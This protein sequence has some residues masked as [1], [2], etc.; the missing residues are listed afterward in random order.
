MSAEDISDLPMPDLFRLE[1]ETQ[2]Q[3]LIE[4]LLL[5]ERSPMAAEPLEASM[6]AAHSLKG[7]ARIVGLTAGVGVAHAMED[8]LV[9]A[10]RGQLTVGQAQIDLLL[11]GADLLTRIAKAPEAE[12]DR[13]NGENPAEVARFLEALSAALANGH[14]SG[15]DHDASDAAVLAA[16][17]PPAP[18][19]GREP[20][21]PEHTLES[22]DRVLRV[23]AEN[24]NRLL[25]LA[26]ESLVESRWLKPFAESLLRL[27]RLHY[28][29]G[30]GLEILRETRSPQWQDE[31]TQTVLAGVQQKFLE[32]QRLL[33]DRLVELELFD[34]RSTN[35]AHRLYEEASACR[36]RPFA[37]GVQ[38]FP[39]MVRDLGRALGKQ[40]RLEI[41]GLGT[42]VDRDVLEKLDAPLGHLLRNSI[43][44]GIEFP[45]ERGLAGKPAEGVVRLE[46]RHSAGMLQVMVSDDG[47]GIDLEKL[48]AAIVERKLTSAEMA[49]KLS[50]AELLEFL[51]LPGFTMK[52]DVTEISGR[53]VGLDVV[54]DMVRQVRGT[55]RVSTE[56]GKGARFVLQLPLTLSVMRTLLVDVAGEPY[57]F[58]LAYILRTLKLPKGRVEVLE[59]RQHFNLD[60]RPVGLVAVHQILETGEPNA[61]ADE[62]SI[63]V[64]G[65]NNHAYGL[66]VDRF[67]GEREL[68]VQP[69]DGRLGKIKDISAGALMEDGSPV[70]IVDVEDMTRS[71][72][73]LVSSGRLSKIG[74]GAPARAEKKN[75]R[76]LVVDDS[77]TVREVERK[78][79][80]SR[81]YDVEIAIDGMDGW[82]AVRTNHFNLVITDIDMPRMDGFELVEMIKKDPVLK[83]LP[84]MIVSYKDREEDRMRGLEAGA[85]YYLTKGS[86]HDETLLQAVVDLIGESGA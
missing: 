85:D 34:G 46:A 59:G 22:S 24:L 18:Q 79:L 10:Q 78:L 27:K 5:L 26:G 53:G 7:A 32:C 50:E 60:G 38:S 19:A 43:D 28:D 3:T 64:V 61:A 51:F 73:K 49:V 45:E 13:W 63:I 15:A 9:A 40:V 58:P 30:K 77:L 65:N 83:S 35:L 80:G 29:L 54:Q 75:K 82:N 72:E 8:C 47:A 14:G 86:F 52:P 66:L 55:V 42:Q 25:G 84:V 76:V 39:R 6:R 68:V 17:A 67:L 44:H 70:L 56:P 81:G 71:V 36:M 62:L 69:L 74:S 16:S 2:V 23:T 48:R 12:I 1:A 57:A 4:N 41:V 33:S 20:H 31:R 37:D 11:R 21:A